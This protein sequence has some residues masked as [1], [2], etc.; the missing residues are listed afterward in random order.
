MPA[1][2]LT[3][4]LTHAF[5]VLKMRPNPTIDARAWNS[6]INYSLAR[7]GVH[8]PA[9]FARLLQMPR[10]Q[11]LLAE[12]ERELDE[13][14]SIKAHH[15]ISERDEKM[16]YHRLLAHFLLK[17]MS[18]AQ[19]R[20]ALN[21]EIQKQI[22]ALLQKNAERIREA[23]ASSHSARGIVWMEADDAYTLALKTADAL[24]EEKAMALA[25]EEELLNAL[26][27]SR[28]HLVI[29]GEE[30][31]LL[32]QHMEHAILRGLPDDLQ[33]LEAHLAQHRLEAMLHA[34]Q[35]L[36]HFE[37]LQLRGD[38]VNHELTAGVLQNLIAS[39]H[40]AEWH[41]VVAGNRCAFD[42]NWEPCL[43]AHNAAYILRPELQVVRDGNTCY[44]LPANTRFEDLSLTAREEARQNFDAREPEFRS[45]KRAVAQQVET[46]KL[47][48][49]RQEKVCQMRVNRLSE[50]YQ[51]LL[52]QR[53]SILESREDVRKQSM[54]EPAATP[55]N[56][57]YSAPASTPL[58]PRMA[59]P[60]PVPRPTPE[61]S[62]RRH[63]TIEHSYR[64]IASQMPRPG[65]PMPRAI[66]ENPQPLGSLMEMLALRHR[67]MQSQLTAGMAPDSDMLRR[68]RAMMRAP[69]DA[70]AATPADRPNTAPT[71]FSMRPDPWK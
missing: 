32:L 7:H 48:L 18:R 30:T 22:D 16:L 11:Q 6:Y 33:F 46:S 37:A 39:Q 50:D 20:K 51:S 66:V 8:S 31:T 56:M 52:N 21:R 1:P 10:A 61:D 65:M 5:D 28:E 9:D 49:Q 42:H 19:H 15:R 63:G 12:T 45:I 57:E 55:A 62:R 59:M 2:T 54:K 24:I 27:T 60:V 35:A 17:K 58:A 3:T 23:N 34:E 36:A 53:Q 64:T 69:G 44:L 67:R 47:D 14:D 25:A 13:I 41:D 4:R 40:L 70:P 29:F 43:E 26:R 38:A 71:P 68:V